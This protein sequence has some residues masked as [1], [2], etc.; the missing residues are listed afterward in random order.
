MGVGCPCPLTLNPRGCS[1]EHSSGGPAA[2]GPQAL[3]DTQ[4]QRQG[5]AAGVFCTGGSVG[6]GSGRSALPQLASALGVPPLQ[7]F[8]VEA[9]DVL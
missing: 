9:E 8:P 4:G 2:T 5:W 3:L 6:G 7:R 1:Q